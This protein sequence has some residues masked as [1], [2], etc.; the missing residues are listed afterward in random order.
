METKTVKVYKYKNIKVNYD[1][2]SD[3][4]KHAD[5]EHVLLG[6]GEAVIE[7]LPQETVVNMHIEALKSAKKEV[8]ANCEVMLEKLDEKIQSLMAISHEV[9]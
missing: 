5:T 6:V 8:Q 9:A 7:L 1:F 3:Y 2:I 4:E